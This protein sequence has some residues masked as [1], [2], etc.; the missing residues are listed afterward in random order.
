MLTLIIFVD[1][2]VSLVAEIAQV[3]SKVVI[4]LAPHLD[5]QT[6]TNL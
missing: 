3:F 5:E 2:K 4:G 1:N 6:N